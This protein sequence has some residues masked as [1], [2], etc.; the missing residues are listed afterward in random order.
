MP[1]RDLL[2]FLG[3]T[4]AVLGLA[5]GGC[6]PKTNGQ[7]GAAG[8]GRP[9]ILRVTLNPNQPRL[10]DKLIAE[11]EAIAGS[12]K[13]LISLTYRWTRNGEPLSASGSDLD[14]KT[15]KKGDRIGLTVIPKDDQGEGTS[16]NVPEIR[17]GNS[18]PIVS[19]AAF[20]PTNP[21]VG[22]DLTA[23][24]QGED[25]DGD[26]V[27]FRYQWLRN[28]Q[29]I[30]E[31]KGATLAGNLLK[32]GDAIEAR[33]VPWDGSEAGS[34]RALGPVKV[35]GRPPVI[36]SEPP[37][38]GFAGG[39]FSYRVTASEPDGERVTFGLTQGP[40]GMTINPGDGLI[41]WTLPSDRG[42]TY[43]VTVRVTDEEGAWEDQ[44]FTLRY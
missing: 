33:I 14:T 26:G 35:T 3:V 25:P 31:A 30:P 10:G 5:L 1:G 34:E 37:A 2:R 39:V 22:E 28:G 6:K 15:F 40:S 29:P 9:A 23:V 43:A 24:V 38:E 12:S 16:Y 4:T 19:Q 27:T 36:T 11:A 44:S 20:N 13:G 21:Q 41:R 7:S 42:K 17:L 18:Q 32:R 8:G